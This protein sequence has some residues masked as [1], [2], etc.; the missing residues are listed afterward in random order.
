M[1][2]E[3][4]VLLIHTKAIEKFGGSQG[5]RDSHLLLSA[6]Q[7]PYTTFDQQELYVSEIDKAT[8]VLESIVR[9]HPF[10]DGNKRT[11]YILLRLWLLKAQMDIVATISEKYDFIISIA[12]GKLSFEEI[13]A[14]IRQKIHPSSEETDAI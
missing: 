1:I 13:K 11:G 9:N 7:R 14:W 4:Q 12:E 10:S 6:I 2:T 8:A 5:V 3:K